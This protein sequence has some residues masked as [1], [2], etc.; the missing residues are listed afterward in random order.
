MR[1]TKAFISVAAGRAEAVGARR[2][3]A[4]PRSRRRAISATK[5]WD[6]GQTVAAA[7]ALQTGCAPLQP[8]STSLLF[9]EPSVVTEDPISGR[10]LLQ[11]DRVNSV[12]PDV[13]KLPSCSSYGSHNT[14]WLREEV[15]R[16]RLGLAPFGPELA[17]G[18]FH[19]LSSV[20]VEP[21]IALTL[22]GL[23]LFIFFN[24]VL[25]VFCYRRYELG[26]CG[27]PF[28]TVK[29]YLPREV[30][31]VRLVT[32]LTLAILIMIAGTALLVVNLSVDNGTGA[33]VAA[34]TAIE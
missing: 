9:G 6:F 20:Y 1:N 18:T 25:T 22:P 21:I 12:L 2:D 31:A 17:E 30:N 14:T 3:V 16:W 24:L 28:P 10:L 26:L 13:F 32:T 11:S 15:P 29:Q 4:S 34:T 8:M 23:S 27:E 5:S 33:L 7:A 19:P